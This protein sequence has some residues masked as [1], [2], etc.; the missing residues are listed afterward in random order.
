MAS[1]WPGHQAR[2]PRQKEATD[3]AN[4]PLAPGGSWWAPNR[5][6]PTIKVVSENRPELM[7]QSIILEIG[8]QTLGG[9]LVRACALPWLEILAEIERNPQFLFYFAKNPRKFEEFIAGAYTRAG[10]DKVELTPRSGDGGRDVI[11]TKTGFG[12]I[13]ILEQTKAY[14]PGHLVTHDDVRA[15][16]GVLQT[17]SNSSKGIITTT[18]DFQPGI[19]KGYEFKPFMPHRLETKNGIQLIEWLKK[20]DQKKNS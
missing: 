9:T 2:E 5:V 16:L 13:R 15:M 18:S 14:S 3:Y 6:S 10:Y 19:F 7:L 20:I 12:S 8:E 4:L 11:A 17:D 1:W